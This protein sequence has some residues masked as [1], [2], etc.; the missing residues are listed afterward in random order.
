MCLWSD[1]HWGE[2][3]DPKQIHNANMY[4]IQIAQDRAKRLVDRTIL[5][6]K[7][8]VNSDYPG[9]VVLMAGDMLSGDIHEELT[10]TNELT[11]MQAL[12]DLPVPLYHHHSLI[13]GADG[14]RLAKRDRSQTLR[15]RLS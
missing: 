1:W 13:V 7:H 8:Y 3:V 15:A 11:T 5:L 4:N 2:V 14:H 6:C 9:I 10:M 12:L